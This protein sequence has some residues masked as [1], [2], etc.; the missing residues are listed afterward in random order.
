MIIAKQILAAMIMTITFEQ[1]ANGMK[2]KFGTM[3]NIKQ[4]ISLFCF[5]LYA[6]VGCLSIFLPTSLFAYGNKDKT[7]TRCDSVRGALSA[8]RTCYNVTY[9]D[10]SVTIDTQKQY[11]TGVNKIH[12]NVVETF[13]VMQIDLFSNMIIDRIEYKGQAM[14]YKR[15]CDAVYVYTRKELT[16]GKGTTGR[17]DVYFRGYPMVAKRAPW[18]GGFVWN[19]DG[20]GN[21]FIAT[22]V[23]GIGASLWWP[24]KEYLGD[25][26]DSMRISI[27]VPQNLTAVSNGLLEGVIKEENNLHTWKWFVSSPINNYNVALNI[28]KY[29]NFKDEFTYSDGEKLNLSYYVLADNV[30]KAK[31]HFAQVKPMLKC[32]EKYLGK[33][34]FM[35]D[36]YKLVET[37]Y[38]GME[39]QSCIAYG[40]GYKGGY[41]GIDF[42]RIGLNFDY[43]I[44]H[45]TG[46][47]WWGNSVSCQ[48]I[49][50]MWI[51]ESFCT[52]TEAIYVECMHDYNTA[53]RYINA[54][55]P[56]IGNK[57]PIIG[58]YGVNNE[59]DHDMYSKGSLILNT[60]RH[61]SGNDE[62]WW[63][64]IKGISD[65]AF[66]HRNTNASEILA[67]INKS[68]DYDFTKIFNQ[69]FRY[70]D[71]P[72]FV[73]SLK[74]L[75]GS[76]YELTYRWQ[77]DVADFAMPLFVSIGKTKDEKLQCTTA[78]QVL[79]IK[80]AS[81]EKFRV[82]EDLTYIN[83]VKE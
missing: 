72:K 27:T 79:T 38:V 10:L 58:V 61:V 3:K 80:L 63:K 83:V 31:K 67:Y 77:T 59:G 7:F 14:P 46:H 76:K 19:K 28:G 13:D 4:Q 75:K 32:Y 70:A 41:S 69:Y 1:N 16:Q 82:N 40:N 78:A 74:K 21:Q 43:I 2:N 56:S 54:K 34:P 66:K 73:Y 65:T 81:P 25:E 26:P 8:E 37:P 6:F 9:Y 30:A 64:T 62:L 36:G 57:S 50:D 23:Q 11:I 39:H 12:Y 45:E 18:D 24:T 5:L 47:E 33:Y 60:F 71:I 42:S 51:H 22:S 15:D 20:N 49:A 35:R 17:L 29:E 53:I 55:R 48:D 44:I 52:Y 68:T